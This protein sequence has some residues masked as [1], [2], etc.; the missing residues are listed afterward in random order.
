MNIRKHG[1]MGTEIDPCSSAAW[2]DGWRDTPEATAR[3]PRPIAVARTWLAR[4]GWRRYGLIDRRRAPQAHAF[5][6]TRL[7]PFGRRASTDERA[8]GGYD[9]VDC[10]SVAPASQTVARRASPLRARYWNCSVENRGAQIDQ[11]DVDRLAAV[12]A[13]LALQN[14]LSAR[15]ST[16]AMMRLARASRDGAPPAFTNRRMRAAS[17]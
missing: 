12:C 2:F 11:P 17:S 7:A 15:F 8:T 5:S 6:G 10:P 4:V 14:H 3:G 9:G 13:G 16:L 1:E